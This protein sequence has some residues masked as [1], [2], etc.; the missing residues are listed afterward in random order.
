MRFIDF[1]RN[2]MSASLAIPF[3]FQTGLRISEI[4]ALKWSDINEEKESCI[5]VQRMETKE[6]EKLPDGSWSKEKPVIIECTKSY[7]G[8]RNVYL[9]TTARKILNQVKTHN[10]ETGYGNYC[11]NRKSAIQTAQTMEKALAH[12]V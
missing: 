10:T 8:N 4:V 6:F 5:H 1:E 2:N 9:T 3:A 7:A 12:T 11:F